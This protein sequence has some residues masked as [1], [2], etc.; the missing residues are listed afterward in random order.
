M[1]WIATKSSFKTPKKSLWQNTLQV[2]C[3]GL[4]CVVAYALLNRQCCVGHQHLVIV[5]EPD[6]I[7]ERVWRFCRDDVSI[8][9][10]GDPCDFVK[11]LTTDGGFQGFQVTLGTI[12]WHTSLA[13]AKHR[14]KDYLLGGPETVRVR[15]RPAKGAPVREENNSLKEHIAFLKQSNSHLQGT[16]DKVLG[17]SQEN[18]KRLIA[19]NETL[20][21]TISSVSQKSLQQAQQSL[22]QA[23]VIAGRFK[24]FMD[25]KKPN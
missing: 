10:R 17:D 2:W 25:K 24:S 14:S 12:T 22:E 18:Y 15:K 5:V 19:N 8:T 1:L 6:D 3:F 16:V 7:S 21:N 23:S 11:K 20:A 13:I 9:S 4:H